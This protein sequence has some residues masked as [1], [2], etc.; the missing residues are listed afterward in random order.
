MSK[1]VED[2]ELQTLTLSPTNTNED[3]SSPFINPAS[4]ETAFPISPPPSYSSVTTSSSTLTGE[5]RK[6]ERMASAPS[7]SCNKPIPSLRVSTPPGSCRV[8][9]TNERTNDRK[10]DL[11]KIIR[12]RPTPSSSIGQKKGYKGPAANPGIKAFIVNAP[13]GKPASLHRGQSPGPRAPVKTSADRK[14][15]IGGTDVTPTIGQASFTSCNPV[16]P[17]PLLPRPPSRGT[18]SALRS[19]ASRAWLNRFGM[20]SGLRSRTGM[21]ARQMD[22]PVQHH[23]FLADVADVRQIEQGLLQLME[24]FQAGSLRAFGKDSRLKQM[25]AI[26]EQ[27]ERLARLHFD[28]G[29]EQDLYPPLSE[30]GLRASH[31]NMRTLMEKL[32]QLSESIERMHTNTSSSERRSAPSHLFTQWNVTDSPSSTTSRIHHH[33]GHHHHNPHHGHHHHHHHHG[34][35][36]SHNN[37]T[38][39]T[40]TESLSSSQQTT[41]TNTRNANTN[42]PAPATSTPYHHHPSPGNSRLSQSQPQVPHRLKGTN[43]SHLGSLPKTGKVGES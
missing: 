24:D 14:I 10:M 36:S 8:T 2:S 42:S 15:S 4:D 39:S 18:P 28:T 21:D 12:E 5:K 34:H 19:E 32:A 29:A 37:T 20:R 13:D 23:T 30:D 1:K 6:L 7:G 9:Y 27:Q 22:R 25:E 43:G 31:N 3:E 11:S 40:V 35:H 17:L 26:R 33:H 41:P 38:A 16:S